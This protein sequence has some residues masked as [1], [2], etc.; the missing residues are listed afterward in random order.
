MRPA[1]AIEAVRVSVEIERR[2]TEVQARIRCPRGANALRNAELTVLSGNQSPS[3]PGMPPGRRTGILRNAWSA[4]SS[5]GGTS[6]SFGIRSYAHYAGYLDEGTSR[7]A[8]RPFVDRI[9]ETAEPDIMRIFGEI[10]G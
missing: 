1:E 10:G 6:C 4:F 5:G 8:A 2:V 7:M 3:P 9:R